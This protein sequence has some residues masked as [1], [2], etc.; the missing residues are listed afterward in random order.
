MATIE[1]VNKA[2]ETVDSFLDEPVS[3]TDIEIYRQFNDRLK[4]MEGVLT[5]FA[6]SG[7]DV[8]NLQATLKE[9]R[10]KVDNIIREFG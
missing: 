6:R 8:R 7:M 4:K 10:S 2:L 3:E 1:E 5:R 9:N